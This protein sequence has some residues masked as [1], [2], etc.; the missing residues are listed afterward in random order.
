MTSFGAVLKPRSGRSSRTRVMSRALAVPLAVVLAGL[1][2]QSAYARAGNSPATVTASF[3]CA[4]SSITYSFSAFPNAP[5]NTVTETVLTGSTKL[6][7]PEDWIANQTFTF[8]GPSGE[9][10]V[11]INL[12][13]L[14]KY[15]LDANTQ[16]NTNGVHGGGDIKLK[17][18]CFTIEKEQEI[19][20][21]QAGF[22]QSELEG[23]VGQT[24]DYRIKVKNTG[25]TLFKF[26]KL[27]DANCEHISTT[28]TVKLAPGEEHVYTCHHTLSAA[29]Q[30][31][32]KH[33]NNATITGNETE[34][35]TSNTV[36]VNVKYE[37][38]YTIEK[39]QRIEG[40]GL[41]AT[42]T[43]TGTVGEKVEYEIIVK[44]E[45][46]TSLKF[47]KLVDANCEGISPSGEVEL[48]PGGE[49]VYTCSHELTSTGSYENS[50]SI[51]GNEGTGTKSSNTVDVTVNSANV[52]SSAPTGY[53]N[54]GGAAAFSLFALNG[55]GEQVAELEEQEGVL[56]HET[57]EGD[58][59]VG[60]KATVITHPPSTVNGNVY[61]DSEGSFEGPGEVTGTVF[62]NQN[63]D[64]DRMD[65]I[66]ASKEGAALSPTFTYSNIT[67]NTTVTGVA[68][69]N[70]IDVTGNITLANTS[71]TLSG[72][73]NAFF[74]VNVAGSISL[75]GHGEIL[76][77]G[78]AKSDHVLVNMTG[79]GAVNTSAEAVIEGTLLGPYAEGKLD[80]TFGPL[81]LGE[82]FR[83]NSDALVTYEGCNT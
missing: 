17:Q 43:L 81:L 19:E 50:A 77:G 49:Q 10:T 48:A 51:T 23:Q 28:T 82:N 79:E 52:C 7:V 47:T 14:K 69:L 32:E 42:A 16:W 37:P 31:A 66:N 57:I 80:G 44:D 53:P 76:V 8:N 70:V 18:P 83:L 38:F 55:N 61:V 6:L 30:E 21:S 4:T 64:G 9:N 67:S 62:T 24:V 54:L 35:K 11:P 34:T 72:P 65:A 22:T 74:V 40:K 12:S 75:T 20:G 78:Q 39:L 26:G 63:L 3:S 56:S 2:A 33:E 36:V 1:F 27:I 59:G 25:T 73:A 45:G 71:L 41:F 29:D 15:K 60:P 5:N 58:V 46:N 68:G 13:T